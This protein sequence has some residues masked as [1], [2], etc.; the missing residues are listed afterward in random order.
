MVQNAKVQKLFILTKD[1][2]FI[3]AVPAS[4]VAIPNLQS[5]NKNPRIKAVP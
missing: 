2:R 3:F 4:E 1:Y 5:I